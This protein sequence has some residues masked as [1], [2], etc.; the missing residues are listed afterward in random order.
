MRSVD[1]A[2]H[3]T[4]GRRRTPLAALLLLLGMAAALVFSGEALASGTMAAPQLG[5]DAPGALTVAWDT[6]SP[7]PK[8]YRLTYA[9]EDGDYLSYRYENEA[10]RGNLYPGGGETSLTITGLTPGAGYKV[11]MRARYD[12]TSGPWSAEAVL[13]VRDN[14]PAAPT[15]LSLSAAHDSVTLSWTA[16]EG[17]SVAGYRI[18]RG[19]GADGLTAL[20][21]DTASTATTYTDRS[22]AAGT[23]YR[24]AVAAINGDGDV[25]AQAGDDVTTP[26]APDK[27]ENNTPRQS[28]TV[29][30]KPTGLTA[31]ATGQTWIELSWTAPSNNGGADIT[32]YKIEVS[33]DGSTWTDLDTGDNQPS[34]THTGLAAGST[35]HY[36]V[37]AINSVG[38]GPASDVATDTANALVGNALQERDSVSLASEAISTAFT[39]G[40]NT[41]G[42]TV[43]AIEI[44]SE[45]AEGDDFSAYIYN[46]NDS[47]HPTTARDVLSTSF[48]NFNAGRVRIPLASDRQLFAANTTYAVVLTRDGTENVTLGTTASDFEDDG[49]VS[50]FSISN[51][52]VSGTRGGTTWSNLA[53]SEVVLIAV[54]GQARTGT[55]P[56]KPTALAAVASGVT[57]I[58]LSWTAPSDTGTSAITGY[59]IEVSTDGS[60][61]T[62]LVASQTATTYEHTG[63]AAGSTRH[64]RVSAINEFGT[65][66]ASDTAMETSNVL[67]GNALQDFST[68]ISIDTLSYSQAFTTGGNSGGY[69][70]NAIE[71]VSSDDEGDDF[72]ADLYATSGGLPTG[73]SLASLAAPT[74][75]G[76]FSAGRVIFTAPANTRLAASTTYAVVIARDG[77]GNVDLA[78]PSSD[79]EDAG[80]ASGFSIANAYAL[81][82]LGSWALH[83]SGRSL[84]IAVRGEA[85]TNTAPGK[86]TG[87]AAG[88][89]GQTRIVLV[90]RAPSDTGGASLTGYKIEVSTNGTTWTDLVASQ[91]ATTYS[92]TG[93]TVGSTRH[94]RVSAINSLGTG[95]PSNVATETTNVLVSNAHQPDWINSS[96]RG[97]WLLPDRKTVQLFMTGSAT[98]GYTLTSIEITSVDRQGDDFT[99]EIW[100]TLPWAGAPWGAG[101]FPNRNDVRVRLNR[102]AGANAFQPGQVPFTPQ[103]NTTLPLDTPY[104]VVFTAPSGVTLAPDTVYG[105]ALQPIGTE[106]VEIRNPTTFDEDEGAASGWSINDRY[107]NIGE[108]NSWN[109]G[110]S[111]PIKVR[112]SVKSRSL[113]TTANSEATGAPTITGAVRVGETL[114]AGTS[115]ISDADGMTSAKFSYQWIRTDLATFTDE[116]ISGATGSTY[117][118]TDDDDGKGIKVR[119]SFTDDAGNV[120]SLASYTLLPALQTDDDSPAN[121]PATGAPA[122]SGTA[123][124]GLTLTVSTTGIADADGLEEVSYSYQWLADDAEITGA[125]GATYTLLAADQGKAIKVR[126]SF[127]DDA[128]NPESLTSAATVSVAARPNRAATGAPTISGTAQVGE[129]LTASTTGISDA[130]GLTNATFTYGWLADDAV[131]AGATGS[132]YTLAAG[133]Q[134]KAIKVRVSFTDDA[135][136][137]ET[138]TSAATAAVVPPPLT[139]EVRQAP[140]SHDGSTTFAFELHF[141]EELELSYVTLR[142]HAFTVSGGSIQNARRLTQGSNLGWE[143]TVGPSSTASVTI[144]LPV[145]T[146]CE[147]EGALCTDDGR[148]LSKR[149]EVRVPGPG[150]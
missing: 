12:G 83:P 67:V 115:G 69:T 43:T 38:T 13:R 45:D 97:M 136:N 144:V 125:T 15:G 34:Y 6:P 140:E 53:N 106:K 44:I 65:G 61:W 108:R 68:G 91:T 130:D 49:K 23:A 8:D 26:A 1:N 37:S 129:T 16:P 76:A 27:G 75:A 11:K 30:G 99:A 25:G 47:G 14:P 150:G 104:Q 54:R 124:V 110:A 88:A 40:S 63:L 4:R 141:S 62:D 122:I 19:P 134:G 116:E 52:S 149:V 84:S 57:Q 100:G 121:T 90:W 18:W 123:Q 145:T 127:T 139:A 24:Y 70:L 81:Y 82:A 60:N 117:A 56:G 22:V 17:A 92:H 48:V 95:A 113:R 80:K 102:P 66:T 132:S 59:K 93:L 10:E 5:S 103:P 3:T 87:L 50:G 74:G 126:V 114:T 111:L 147:A 143:I 7:A 71:V 51:V 109:T 28:T 64:Y 96:A 29:P 107:F 120:E 131:I 36:R 9:P 85:G 86:P 105:V 133:D 21:D 94:Y 58:N 42:Y 142:D 135:G 89:L 138:L 146:D 79:D 148:K 31:T 128:G 98:G 112:G 77:A 55:A 20:V 119:V 78:T 118:V 35:R 39:T 73:N 46:T 32:G 101:H 137:A 41:G 2:K 33:T 72:T